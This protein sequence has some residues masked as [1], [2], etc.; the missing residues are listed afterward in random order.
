MTDE[1]IIELDDS[2]EGDSLEDGQESDFVNRLRSFISS[3]KPVSSD[4][5]P[6]VIKNLPFF[7]EAYNLSLAREFTSTGD[8][9]KSL[10]TL[11]D[12][13]HDKLFLETHR[14]DPGEKIITLGDNKRSIFWLLEGELE[15]YEEVKAKLRKVN[16]LKET[17]QCFGILTTLL[18]IPRTAEVIVSK[19]GRAAILEADWAITAI[20]TM[21]EISNFFHILIAKTAANHLNGSYHRAVSIAKQAARDVVKA[22]EESAKLSS[23]LD[24]LK[25]QQ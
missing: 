24:E 9:W 23:L 11:P 19:S 2:D 15:V 18:G 14:R 1:I 12:T 13:E 3:S 22:K 8:F 10:A 5:D 6:E 20:P 7:E 21:P 25:K 16:S 17:G 4:N